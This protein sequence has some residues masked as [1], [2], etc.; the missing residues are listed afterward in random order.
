MRRCVLK[1]WPPVNRA[2]LTGATRASPLTTSTTC[3]PSSAHTH[4]APL[5]RTAG[6][7]LTMQWAP[8]G[9][10]GHA[11]GRVM[12]LS[13]PRTAATP[14]DMFEKGKPQV[15]IIKTSLKKS[16]HSLCYVVIY[17]MK[18]QR[19]PYL[20]QKKNHGKITWLRCMLEAHAWCRR[21]WRPLQRPEAESLSQLAWWPLEAAQQPPPRQ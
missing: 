9:L 12:A 15:L 11:S 7:A 5:S 2:A 14:G 19:K 4:A 17:Q 18:A 1:G 21:A 3:L 10:R 13:L 16:K 20:Q 6:G 8:G